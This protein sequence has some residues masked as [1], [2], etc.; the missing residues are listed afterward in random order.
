[1]EI[2]VMF[3]AVV[4]VPF[5]ARTLSP[6]SPTEIIGSAT[7]ALTA[8]QLLW[9]NLTTD[10]LPAIALGIDPGDPDIMERKPRDPNES[11]FTR[12]VKL[13]LSLMPILMSSLLLFGY[14]FYR[15]WENQAQLT[16]ARTQLLTAMI[17]M[18]LANAISARSLKYPIWKV[19]PFKNKFLWYAVLSSFALQLVVLY[20]PGLNVL[21]DVNAPELIDWAFAVLFTAI[22][23]IAL[24]TGKHI[25]SRRRRT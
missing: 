20:T 9:V 6:G 7:I 4:S 10:G 2:I 21:F 5:L 12:D 24:E 19:G 23:F 22:V 11:V 17:L 14:F 15:P 8:A 13:Y 16:E 1:M 18:E 3:V 25:A